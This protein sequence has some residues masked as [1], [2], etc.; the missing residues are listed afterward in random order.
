MAEVAVPTARAGPYWEEPP[1]SSGFEHSLEWIYGLGLSRSMRLV[2]EKNFR[3]TYRIAF[4]TEMSAWRLGGKDGVTK[5][6][7]L[8]AM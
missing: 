6:K 4:G 3:I 5:K 8:E 7:R 1:L 2:R